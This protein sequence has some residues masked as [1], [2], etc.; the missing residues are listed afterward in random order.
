M[1]FQFNLST[2]EVVTTDPITPE[3]IKE[4]GEAQMRKGLGE[5]LN[6]FNNFGRLTNIKIK[7]VYYNPA[8]VVCVQHLDHE[9][10]KKKWPDLDWWDNE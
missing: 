5:L 2:G 3:L 7:S 10:L 8:H 6:L 9:W 1:Y 4:Y